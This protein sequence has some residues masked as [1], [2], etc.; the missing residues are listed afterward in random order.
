MSQAGLAHKE[1]PLQHSGHVR[2]LPTPRLVPK[3]PCSDCLLSEQCTCSTRV[4]V[5]NAE[6]M[7]VDNT[8]VRAHWDYCWAMTSLWV[9]C[10]PLPLC[11]SV[12]ATLDVTL[13]DKYL[14]RAGIYW[15]MQRNV[16]LVFNELNHTGR[17]EGRI[18]DDKGDRTA[19]GTRQ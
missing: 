1:R 15:Y 16:V 7:A 10:I 17:T 8:S 19:A 5:I 6:Q 9:N 4:Y 3:P 11:F 13:T 18:K 12:R 2:A 14:P